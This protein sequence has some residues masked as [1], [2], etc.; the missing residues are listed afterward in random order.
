VL[1]PAP[2]PGLVIRYS[3]LWYSEDLEGR[4]EGEEGQ[5]AAL[6]NHCCAEN[7]NTGVIISPK[8]TA[9]PLMQVSP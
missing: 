8:P 2:V 7:G 9:R 5:K 4:E 6:R 3:S 1:L